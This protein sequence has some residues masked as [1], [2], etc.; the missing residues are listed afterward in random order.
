[1]AFRNVWVITWVSKSGKL[2]ELTYNTMEEAEK[3]ADKLMDREERDG[4]QRDW[5]IREYYVKD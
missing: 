3:Q 4:I 1:M 2:H 5:I